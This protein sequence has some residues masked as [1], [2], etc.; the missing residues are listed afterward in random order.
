MQCRF[1]TADHSQPP[2]HS[3]QA[4]ALVEPATLLEVTGHCTHASLLRYWLAGHTAGRGRR[5]GQPAMSVIVALPDRPGRRDWTRRPSTAL[6]ALQEPHSPHASSTTTWPL[7]VQVQAWLLVEP[8]PLPAPRGQARQALWSGAMCL[9]AGQPAAA[10]G[11][12]GGIISQ[13]E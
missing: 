12:G 6:G 10:G 1:G 5:R 9:L 11:R 4:L 8:A 7:M 13:R 3:L 2:P